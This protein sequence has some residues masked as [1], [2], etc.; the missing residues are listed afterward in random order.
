MHGGVLDFHAVS[1]AAGL[2]EEGVYGVDV[3]VPLVD[4]CFGIGLGGVVGNGVDNADVSG[5][6]TVF[7]GGSC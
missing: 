6:A 3:D 7:G 1:K 2:V 4:C 5:L